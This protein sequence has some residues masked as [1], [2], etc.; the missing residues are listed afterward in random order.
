MTKRLIKNRLIGLLAGFGGKKGK[1]GKSVSAGKVVL[2]TLLYLYVAC[3]FLFLSVSMSLSF[4]AVLIPGGASWL[5]YSI[6]VLATFTLLFVFSIFETKG[7]LFDCKDNDLLLSMPIKTGSIAISRIIV[8]LIYGYIEEAVIMLPCIVIY[9]VFSGDAIGIIGGILVSVFL[10]ILA[11]ALASGIGYVVAVLS[12]KMRNKTLITVILSL[13]FLGMYMLGYSKLLSSIED[14]LASG[15]ALNIS[16][17][18]VPFL[19]EIGM[20]P[21]M[22][23][24]NITLYILGCVALAYYVVSKNYIR[25]ITTKH[26]VSRSEYKNKKI[27]KRGVLAALVNREF[28]GFFSSSTY[29]LNGG[30]GIVFE[31][32]LAIVAVVKRNEI[33]NALE[34][35]SGELGFSVGA[36]FLTPIAVMGIVFASSMN[37]I[38]ASAV[39]L[40]GK[41][42]S[43]SKT[44]PVTSKQVL[45]SKLLPQLILTLPASLF[46]SVMLIV[47][48]G[49]PIESWAFYILTPLIANTF[50]AIV[51][52]VIN[53]AC[54]KFNYTTEVQV[55]KQSLSV[56]LVL[57]IQSLLSVAL[58]FVNAFMMFMGLGLFASVI[59]F[60]IFLA[61]CIG[62]AIILFGPSA[63][64]YDKFET[65]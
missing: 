39:S 18:D 28:A 38:T 44:L 51:G 52:L 34:L 25:V 12:K 13:L 7:E 65:L 47:A 6:F 40:E 1:N 31:I 29:I 24:L 60:A 5:Y 8:V 41:Y 14:F 54:P 23:P 26:S 57:T 43:I 30:L 21:L 59:T 16:P 36:D 22:K 46:M 58:F 33:K 64:K 10:P 48:F 62:F 11:T 55:I 3:A 49:A 35:L 17:L 4:G 37:M 50:Y 61:L 27:T 2:F 45:L 15:E 19:Y 42:F 63:R 53:V 20:I 9:G 32:I 56:F